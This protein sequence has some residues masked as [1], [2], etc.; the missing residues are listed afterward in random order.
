MLRV[1]AWSFDRLLRIHA[2]FDHVEQHLQQRLILIVPAGRAQNHEW[3]A[4]FENQRRR[5]SDA[6]TFARRDHVG[7][8]RIS[9]R[10]LQTLAHQNARV[11][12]HHGRQPRAARRRAEHV[13]VFV[14]HI[15]AGR[16]IRFFDLRK[17][18]RVVRN[19][20]GRCEQRLHIHGISG[21]LC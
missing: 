10:R 12:R 15:D 6:R 4:F 13:A 16:V 3:L 20:R 2:K 18:R 9:Q 19:R 7:T 5:Q 21:T 8:A 11:A 1:K 14:D 17:R